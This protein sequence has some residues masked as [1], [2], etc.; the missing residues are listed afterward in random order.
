MLMV[1]FL[2]FSIFIL[3]HF[4]VK[5]VCVLK[6][7]IYI[8]SALLQRILSIIGGKNETEVS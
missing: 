5:G 8:A 6:K 7:V 1:L 4:S 3:M 2:C